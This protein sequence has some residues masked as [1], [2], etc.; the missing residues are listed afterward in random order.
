MVDLIHPHV[1]D[2]ILRHV[3]VSACHLEH[4]AQAAAIVFAHATKQASCAAVCRRLWPRSA[5]RYAALRGT[6]GA[7]SRSSDGACVILQCRDLILQGM[8]GSRARIHRYS[9]PLA[10]ARHNMVGCDRAP[11]FWDSGGRPWARPCYSAPRCSPLVGVWREWTS[12]LR[13]RLA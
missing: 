11:S 6:P 4:E 8:V 3:A 9:H 13:A 10:S 12:P 2:A 7:L 1:R 5:P